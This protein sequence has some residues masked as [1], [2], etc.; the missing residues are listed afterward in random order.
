M[1]DSLKLSFN[2]I[3][4]SICIDLKK[5]KNFFKVQFQ[6]ELIL[7]VFGL[8]VIAKARIQGILRL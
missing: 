1:F 7:D 2:G 8:V 3:S 6:L 4:I 5:K